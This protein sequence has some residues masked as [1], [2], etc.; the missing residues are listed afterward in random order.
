M[1]HSVRFLAAGD[2]HAG[3]IP[4][5]RLAAVF[6]A[7]ARHQD[8]A[9]LAAPGD[10]TNE[11][12]P[13]QYSLIQRQ[14]KRLPFP[15]YGTMGNHDALA[16]PDSYARHLFCR[17][18]EVEGP[19]YLRDVNGVRFIFVSTD[20]NTDGVTVSIRTS[21]HALRDA[22][23]SADGPVVVLCHAPLTG[24]VDAAPGRPSFRSDDPQFGLPE[25]QD[26]RRL[27]REA[28]KPVLY[29][30]GHTHSPLEAD[31]L[32]CSERLGDATLH[33]VNVSSPYFTGRDM[34]I[35]APIL[36][37]RF[38]V[39]PEGVDLRIEDAQT[40]ATLLERTLSFR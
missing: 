7:A 21:L 12:L 6:R 4:E 36:L 22:L 9:F 35:H 31:N 25:S 5:D 39:G 14:V 38:E 23:N 32:I 2:L 15:F 34:D 1:N 8:V 33:S 24:T 18:M 28:G 29:L 10:L 26:V 27:V 20:G 19:T 11:A 40:E 13:E 16:G 30:S 17:A 37:Y 3:L